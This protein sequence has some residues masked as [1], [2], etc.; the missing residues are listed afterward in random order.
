[1]WNTTYSGKIC[2]YKNSAGYV[3]ITIKCEAFHAHRLA[4]LYQFGSF[5]ANQIDHINHIRNDNRI[6]NLRECTSQENGKNQ[7]KDKRNSSG[8]AG[9]HWHKRDK[10]WQANIMT[11]G[12]MIHLGYHEEFDSALAARKTAEEK[13]GFHENHGQ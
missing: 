3:E 12:R 4:W 5:P 2:G 9:V 11:G 10:K 13:H 6:I 1:M 7:T 8:A